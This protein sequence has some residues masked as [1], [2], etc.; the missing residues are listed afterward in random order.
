MA[1]ENLHLSCEKWELTNSV[2]PTDHFQLKICLELIGRR[3]NPAP[4]FLPGCSPAAASE[5][6]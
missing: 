6:G 4:T 2:G 5:I 1:R 3:L